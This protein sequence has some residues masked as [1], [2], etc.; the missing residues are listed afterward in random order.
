MFCTGEEAA[1]GT[2]RAVV[3]QPAETQQHVLRAGG[4][5]ALLDPPQ[6]LTPQAQGHRFV[7]FAVGGGTG[8]VE[9]AIAGGLQQDDVVVLAQFRQTLD[10][11]LLAGQ[12]RFAH[13]LG[14]KPVEVVG[15]VDQCIGT[16]VVEQLC[17]ARG[18]PAV[19]GRAGGEETDVF[20]RTEANQRLPK[21]ISAAQ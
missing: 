16:G 21:G 10:R 20:L 8:A 13:R 6:R 4:A 7:F 18:I 9:H 11:A 1:K 12:A 15:K 17:Q 3:Q 14:L 5:H 19:F 2:V